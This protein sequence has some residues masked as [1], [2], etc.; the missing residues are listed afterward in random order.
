MTLNSGIVRREGKNFIFEIYDE[1]TGSNIHALE[2]NFIFI[3]VEML[4][5]FP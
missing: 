1:Q 2:L 4:F 3:I 5:V